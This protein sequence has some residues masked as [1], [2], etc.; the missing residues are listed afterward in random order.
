M[1]NVT[2]VRVCHRLGNEAVIFAVLRA[3]T[4]VGGL[5]GLLIVPLRPEHRV[6]LTPLLTSFILYKVL[7]LAALVRWAAQARAIFLAT[8]AADLAL[9]FVLVSFTGG[10][11]SHFYLL[12]FPL[13]ALNA[14]HF[15]AGIGFGS[16]TLAWLLLV[17]ANWLT[18]PPTLWS[19]I[20]ARGLLLGLLAVALG[21]VATR[22]RQ[23]RTDAERLNVEV[24]SAKSRLAAAEQLA[25]VGRLSSKMAHEVRNPLGAIN[26][27]VEMLEEIIRTQSGPAMSEASDLLRAIREQ[28]WALASLTEEYLVAARL[29]PPRL[30]PES[31]ND[32]IDD[33]VRFL[34]P[35]VARVGFTLVTDLDEKLPSAP[36]DRAL[37]RQ[38]VHNLVK[39]SMDVLSPGGASLHRDTIGKP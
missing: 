15:G 22:E 1:F 3:L 14:Y 7:L 5:A 36:I 27:N 8:L 10:G 37:L 16:A 23:A 38:A 31:V 13:V 33:L 6:H 29:R 4:M 20:V 11:D 18:P 17:A 19:H 21:H 2:A 30:E 28:V 35:L 34:S 25:A 9:V 26:L 32:V 39:N 12:F 24:A